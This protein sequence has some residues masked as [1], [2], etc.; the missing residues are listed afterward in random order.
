MDARPAGYF[1]KTPTRH[2]VHL[3]GMIYHFR[4][5]PN[6]EVVW[7]INFLNAHGGP[8]RYEMN[9]VVDVV[10]AAFE[11]YKEWYRQSSLILKMK[12]AKIVAKLCCCQHLVARYWLVA[13]SRRVS[14]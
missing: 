12:A 3:N 1:K 8:Q 5:K 9:K 6:H 2:P 4:V 7:E 11:R 14:V 13:R 10:V